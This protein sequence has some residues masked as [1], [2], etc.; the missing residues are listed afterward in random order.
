MA[1]RTITW[2]AWVL[3]A[4]VTGAYCCLSLATFS[5][6]YRVNRGSDEIREM[7]SVMAAAFFGSAIVF[8]Y[9]LLS[10]C[11]ILRKTVTKSAGG[12]GYGL[13]TS[14]SIHM[15]ILCSLCGVVLHG[16]EKE[17]KERFEGNSDTESWTK[18]ETGVF[19][20]TFI[21]AYVSAFVYAIFFLI[22]LFT[23][24]SFGRGVQTQHLPVTLKTKPTKSARTPKRITFNED[25]EVEIRIEST[26]DITSL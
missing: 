24:G 2:F 13:I 10:F 15:S 4:F 26:P 12:F 22:L 1:A 8:I 11:V 16:F 14:S 20:A 9:S 23:K 21:L 7:L 5:N 6:T 19:A 18:L 25:E 3:M 17:M